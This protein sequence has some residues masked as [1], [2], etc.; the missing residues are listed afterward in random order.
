MC[1]TEMEPSHI[2]IET[3]GS[4]IMDHVRGCTDQDKSIVHALKELGSGAN[5]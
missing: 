1:D 4:D 5:L 2:H 3:K